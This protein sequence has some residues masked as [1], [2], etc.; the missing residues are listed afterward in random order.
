M[1]IDREIRNL[2]VLPRANLRR[3]FD[4]HT[5]V[6]GLSIQCEHRIRACLAIPGIDN[7]AISDH[8]HRPRLASFIASMINRRGQM[9]PAMPA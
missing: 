4:G 7:L 1:R 2:Q 9:Q 6:V 5:V 8:P 3:V